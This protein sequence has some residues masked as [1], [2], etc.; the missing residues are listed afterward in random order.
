MNFDR[1]AFLMMGLV[2]ILAIAAGPAV[3]FYDDAEIKKLR[4][5]LELAK[6]ET[7]AWLEAIKKLCP[8]KVDPHPVAAEAPRSDRRRAAPLRFTPEPS[9]PVRL[10]ALSFAHRRRQ[11]ARAAP[12]CGWCSSSSL[13]LCG[14]LR[15]AAAMR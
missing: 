13:L 1:V 7:K 3:H 12:A 14:S 2:A 15:G 8:R 10:C 9:V 4:V 6:V 11:P 5:E